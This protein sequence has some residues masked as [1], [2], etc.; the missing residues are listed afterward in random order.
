M[1][2]AVPGGQECLRC[3]SLLPT[4]D[5]GICPTCGSEFGRATIAMPALKKPI[6]PSAPASSAPLPAPSLAAGPV[7]GA[8]ARNNTTLYIALAVIVVLILA[9]LGAILALVFSGAPT[10]PGP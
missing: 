3:G 5:E 6:L 2:D 10:P 4:E 1:S 9:A 7:A 8:P